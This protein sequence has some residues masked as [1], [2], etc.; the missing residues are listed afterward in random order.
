MGKS[1]KRKRARSYEEEHRL[2]R[3]LQK[4]HEK[5]MRQRSPDSENEEI[6]EVVAGIENQGE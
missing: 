2:L 6:Q 4:I 1:S 5:K 3:K